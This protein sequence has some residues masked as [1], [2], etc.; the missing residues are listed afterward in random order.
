V[1][2]CGVTSERA[3]PRR[4][5]MRMKAL[6]LLDLEEVVYPC[7]GRLGLLGA[8]PGP[9]TM[10]AMLLRTIEPSFGYIITIGRLRGGA[11]TLTPSMKAVHPFVQVDEVVLR[12]DEDWPYLGP[13]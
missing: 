3:R 5:P 2:L 4:K 12:H 10:P 8:N 6:W 1:I 9:W 13:G 7:P 11:W